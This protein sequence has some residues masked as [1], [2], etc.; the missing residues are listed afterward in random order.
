MNNERGSIWRKWDFHV[1]TPFS[2]LN[3]GFGEDFDLYVKG[4]FKKAIS[5]K[6][7]A[8]GITD[9]FTIE[10]YK[11][12]KNEYL[13]N[14]LKLK[15]LFAEEEIVLIKDIWVFPN[16]EFRLDTLVNGNRI[17][18]HVIFSDKVP[19][20]TIES[21]FLHE[22][23]FVYQGNPEGEDEKWKLTTR[24]IQELG[25]K[26]KKDHTNFSGETDIIV[27]MKC[28]IINDKQISSVL[29]NKRSKFDG[30]YLIF[31]PADED[32]SKISWDGQ[33]HNLRKVLIQKA[34][35]LF[36][37][38]PKTISWGLG[39]LNESIENFKSEFRSIKPCI[40]GSDAH[41]FAT[42]F[43]PVNDRFCWIKADTTFEGLKHSLIE[44][45]ARIF[46]GERPFSQIR[47]ELNSTK[48]I[49]ELKINKLAS[50]TLEEKW[51]GDSIR[52]PINT[53]LVAIIG[54]KGNGKSAIAD[55][56]GLVG[57]T[58]NSQAFSFLTETKFRKKRPNR[59]ENFEASLIWENGITDSSRLLS[60]D[61]NKSEPEKVKYIPQS[62]LETL[63]T[64]TDEKKFS[65]ELKKVIFSHVDDS[66]KLD[67]YSLDELVDFKSEEIDNGILKMQNELS[68]IN[69][70]IEDL[71]EK[72]T[73]EYRTKIGNSLKQKKEEYEAH[74]QNDPKSHPINEPQKDE[75]IKGELKKIN[76]Q[77][78]ALKA[79]E[80]HLTDHIESQKEKRKELVY[81]LIK[82]QKFEQSLSNFTEE[83]KKLK[84]NY[85][86]DL[87]IYK[88]DF[89]KI[90]TLTIDKTLLE[91]EINDIKKGIIITDNDLNEKLNE[92]S[93]SKLVI[94]KGM[95]KELQ[96]KLDEPSKHY[97]EY[98]DK[99]KIWEEKSKDIIGTDEKQDS[100]RFYERLI[101][102][103]EEEIAIELTKKYQSRFAVVKSIFSEKI[104]IVNLYKELYKPVT[105]FISEYGTLMQENNINLDVSIQLENFEDRFFNHISRGSK[106]S[107][108]GTDGGLATLKQITDGVNFNSE[109][110]VFEFLKAIIEYL[111]QDKRE[112]NNQEKRFVKNQLRDG[113]TTKDF[114]N[115]LFNLNYLKPNYKLRSGNKNIS[116]LSPGER[117]ALLLIFYLLLDKQ[118]IPL[119][120]DQPEE[121]L[122]NQSI[123]RILVKFI[124]EAKKRRQ[125]I[126]VTHN[127]NLAVVCD[128]EQIIIVKIEKENKNKVVIT[129]GSIENSEINEKIVEILEGTFPAFDNRT[130]KYKVSKQ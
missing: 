60:S 32:L 59:S 11:K 77:L 79:A 101:K 109:T 95:I 121:N 89:N 103:L 22:L 93:V 129:S 1:H 31:A 26:L 81:K 8:I 98:L 124:K 122:D 116:E 123:Y 51:F 96:S 38:N 48:Y 56:I 128:A 106:G 69:N 33:G 68:R 49:K 88:I 10:G 4:L 13:N 118:E 83:F 94:N 28:A 47:V 30:K 52:I 63:C 50:S 64:E 58:H 36:A 9:Y 65:E 61:S 17:N 97:Q 19:I 24:N 18:Y 90:V 29:K 130:E 113:T 23:D 21:D 2:H 76:E 80:Q 78:V 6:I 62:Y 112:P 16:I 42:L 75:S 99:V 107:F 86:S 117:G 111:N 92:S 15:Q 84:D 91:K 82:L 20:E 66:E 53:D 71:E 27:G 25:V 104:K 105:E 5:S 46:I 43:N 41:D 54:N 57:N 7:S 102:Y 126:I 127:P 70:E 85:E 45:E 67:K 35:G 40:W 100:I 72:N 115:F 125:I 87:S 108:I 12:I 34:N 114:Y 14:P 44:P 39:Q 74:K 120:I 73:L 119:I 3:N 55:I 37:S 110:E